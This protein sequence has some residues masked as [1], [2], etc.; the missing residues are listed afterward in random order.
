MG[1]ALAIER[2]G[3]VYFGIDA[4]KRSD[5]LCYYVN[6]ESNLKIHRFPSGILCAA[7]GRMAFAQRLYLHEEWFE[8]AEGE[9][10]DKE[11]I[12]RKIIPRYYQEIKDLDG[13]HHPK[14]GYASR[15][16]ADFI[17]ARG[18]DM[19]VIR[20]DLSVLKCRGA[21]AIS[22]NDADEILV[23]YACASGIASP[24]ETVRRA[25]ALASRVRRGI[26]TR[27]FLINTR[28]LELTR[29]E[30]TK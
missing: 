25:F 3:V 22:D 26:S 21:A 9:R 11:F 7:V 1:A 5:N 28:D 23:A 20:G 19:Y 12:V 24:E 30:E 16:D 6:E 4:V 17:L 13:W 18:G 8:L 14:S 10:F 27:G 15:I 2:D 29:M